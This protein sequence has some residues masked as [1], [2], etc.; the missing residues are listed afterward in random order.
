VADAGCVNVLTVQPDLRWLQPMPNLHLLRQLVDRHVQS[1]PV[2]LV[3][4][5]EVFNGV[6]CDYDP[7]AGPMARQFLQ[8]LARACGVAV[9]G[10]SIDYR[11]DDGQRRNTT[12]VVDAQGHE[13]GAYHKRVLFASE[14]SERTAGAGPGVFEVAGARVGVLICADLW[15]AGQARELVDRADLL[16]VPAKTSVP[17]DSHLEYARHL[18]WNLALTRAMETG[19]PIVVS[20]WAESR[21]EASILTDGKKVRTVHYTSGGASI[22]DPGQ[23]PDLAR[24]Q[25][26]LPAGRPGVL[27]GAIDLDAAAAFREYRRSVGL[28]RGGSRH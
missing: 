9:I 22:V 6:P 24:I 16:C 10:G 13:V 19:L 12:F 5:P 17:A 21:H 25:R 1:S 2:D 27:T 18:W 15:D 23:R 20:D 11:H 26:T 28:L 4:L 8:T 3:V 14:Q 7:D